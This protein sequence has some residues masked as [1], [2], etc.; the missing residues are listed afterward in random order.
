MY[1]M[2]T[3]GVPAEVLEILAKEAAGLDAAVSRFEQVQSQLPLPSP[4]ELAAMRCGKRPVSP[5]VLMAGVLQE[6]I[7]STDDF[8]SQLNE[9]IRRPR[10]KVRWDKLTL[11]EI[12]CIESAL[13]AMGA[14][15]VSRKKGTVVEEGEREMK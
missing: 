11:I 4:Q 10:R 8:L 9:E 6:G 13:I 5:V 15:A 2:R 3:A 14:A 12:N 7:V 1:T